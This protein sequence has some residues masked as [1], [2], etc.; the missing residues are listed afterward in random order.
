MK[1]FYFLLTFLMVSVASGHELP[2]V[3]IETPNCATLA[4]A[5]SVSTSNQTVCVNTAIDPIVYVVGNGGTGAVISAGGLPAGITATYNA[6]TAVMTISGTP[7]VIGVFNFEIT[8]TG[9]ECPATLNAV[10]AVLPNA[11]ITMNVNT[12]VPNQIICVN[13]P[14]APIKFNLGNGAT[15][16]ATLGLPIGITGSVAGSVFTISGAPTTVG[17][18][19]Y[20]VTATGGCGNATRTGTLTVISEAL[21][22]LVPAS[23]PLSQIS[24]ELH[25]MSPVVFQAPSNSNI[26][27]TD[28]PGG[29][30]SLNHSMLTGNWELTSS[31]LPIGVYNYEVSLL[32]GNC[33]SPVLSGSV[34]VYPFPFTMTLS[35]SWTG[36]TFETIVFDWVD[37]PGATGY[38]YTY[39]IDEGPQAFSGTTTDTEFSLSGLV[40]GQSV[41]FK[42]SVLGDFC[43]NEMEAHC[44]SPPLATIAFEKDGL[45]YYP[46][47][48]HDLFHLESETTIDSISIFNALG[49]EVRKNPINGRTLQMDLSNFDTG[50]Y[51]IKVVSG[52]S[53]KTIRVL[54]E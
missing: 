16:T 41:N 42:Y 25:P 8:T 43:G 10:I 33:G 47:P 15:G 35:C 17:V 26:Q 51:L 4:L 12:L 24:C 44:T 36:D 39:F 52:S 22:N 13:T 11:T 54:K 5:S 28:A 23:A 30:F 46:N 6:A 48:V 45:A 14:M 3:E 38:S 27:I 53:V 40:A 1:R 49:Q 29:Y 2:I 21:L 18:Y 32:D 7:T 9:G 31:P 20:T 34:T 19:S 50:I 37:V